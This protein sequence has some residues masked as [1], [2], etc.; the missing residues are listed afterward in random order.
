MSDK[1]IFSY[2][3]IFRTKKIFFEFLGVWNPLLVYRKYFYDFLPIESLYKL[4]MF[5]NCY[6]LNYLSINHKYSFVPF[7][8]S[9]NKKK[10][11]LFFGNIFDSK[12]RSA[13]GI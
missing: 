8:N 10:Y 9:T 5:H 7:E 11:W 2:G 4:W 6:T 3:G 1:K 13:Y 12:N